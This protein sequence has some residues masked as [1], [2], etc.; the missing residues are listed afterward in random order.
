MMRR[1]NYYFRIT[2][3]SEE[4]ANSICNALPGIEFELN[5]YENSKNYVMLLKIE[6]GRD[7]SALFAAMNTRK[8]I[9]KGVYI[10]L[11][12]ESD[13]DGVTV[14][15]FVVSFFKNIDCATMDFSFT[16]V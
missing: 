3:V 14:P 4:I 15:E 6:E 5:N 11:V 7:Y 12:T 1:E 8:N 10:S 2:D 16:C 9:R 13:S